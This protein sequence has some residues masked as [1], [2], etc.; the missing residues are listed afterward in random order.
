MFEY[1]G[2][3][4]V[5]ATAGD[6]EPADA[7]VS[8]D[9]VTALV[10]LLASAPGVAS[11]QWVNGTLQFHVGGFLNH[12]GEQGRE[13]IEAFHSIGEIAPGS[14]GL[15]YVH[16]D[17]DAEAKNEFVVYVMRRGHVSAERDQ[18]LS[19]RAPTIEDE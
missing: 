17:E 4:T 2:W 15:L 12:R 14:Y 19:P 8:Y 7:G 1:H 13:V 18:F 6:E 10:E 11:L 16:D 5:Q 3:A 9:R